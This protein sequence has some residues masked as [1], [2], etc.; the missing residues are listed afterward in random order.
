MCGL[1][2]MFHMWHPSR[3]PQ[4]VH[5]SRCCIVPKCDRPT[6][7]GFRPVNMGKSTDCT[8][9]ERRI[10]KNLRDDGKT[11]SEIARIIGRSKTLVHGALKP[12]NTRAKRGRP[13]KT[14]ESCDRRLI[15]KVKADPFI[16]SAKLQSIVDAQVSPRTIRRRLQGVRLNSRTPRRVPLLSKKNI[17]KRLHFARTALEVVDPVERD[18]QWFDVLWSDET[19]VNLF[20]SD[21][22]TRVRRLPNTEFDPRHTVKTIKHG[23]GNIMVWGCFSYHGVGPLFWIKEIMTKEVYRDILETVMLPYAEAH[24]PDGWIFQQ[25]NDPKHSS[26]LVQQWFDSNGVTVMEWPSQSPDLNP[27]EHLWSEV[28]R[29]LPKEKP[30]NREQLWQQIQ[31]AWNGIPKSVCEGLVLS[32]NR[33]CEEVIKNNGQA[34]RY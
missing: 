20:G 17:G 18:R 16:S 21:A 31:A 33:R 7:F 23:G 11:L 10:I 3:N 26:K 32:M 8:P 5:I 12:K 6:K 19:K 2:A 27:I 28:K 15:R 24:M 30:T 29:A 34:T 4:I 14:T 25:D 9:E 13:R 1:I 22:P